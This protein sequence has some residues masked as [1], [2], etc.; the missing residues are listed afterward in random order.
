MKTGR[1][2]AT[3]RRKAPAKDKDSAGETWEKQVDYPVPPEGGA[4]SRVDA[5]E[6]DPATREDR[7][8]LKAYYRAQQRGFGGSGEMQDWLEAEREVDGEETDR[9]LGA[10]H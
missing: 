7:I 8:R 10:L 2:N 5:R 6:D 3:D 1:S 4:G 9:D